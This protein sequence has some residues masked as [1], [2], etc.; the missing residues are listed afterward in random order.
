MSPFSR[1]GYC[2]FAALAAAN[3]VL[4][5]NAPADNTKYRPPLEPH[6]IAG[7]TFGYNAYAEYRSLYLIVDHATKID[8]NGDE[9]KSD[10]YPANVQINFS[11]QFVA[12][13][14]L[15]V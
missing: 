9:H 2:L 12:K 14:A 6:F 4:A 11:V 8:D 3:G 10:I 13:T 7:Q 1:H 5:A 15:A